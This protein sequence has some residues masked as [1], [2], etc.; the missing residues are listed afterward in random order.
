VGEAEYDNYALNTPCPFLNNKLCT[1]YDIRPNGCR[2]FPNTLFGM[3][4]QDCEA[5]TLLKRQR[6]ALKKG[7][8]AK[9]TYYFTS[10]N[11]PI[12]TSI[13]TEEQ[14]QKCLS[15]LHQTGTTKQQLTLFH[16][17]NSKP[18]FHARKSLK[19]KRKMPI[20]NKAR[21]YRLKKPHM[22]STAKSSNTK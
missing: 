11:Q 20:A 5:L 4:T 17:F 19:C 7:R 14:Y 8:T 1:I 2:Y 21:K 16:Q 10:A 12:K 18:N 22:L 9:E 6:A 3:Q 15:K 13:F